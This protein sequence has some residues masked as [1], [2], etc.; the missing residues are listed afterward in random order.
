MAQITPSMISEMRKLRGTGLSLQKIASL[1]SEKHSIEISHQTISYHLGKV[2][3]EMLEGKKSVRVIHVQ[4]MDSGPRVFNLDLVTFEKERG[5]D[6]VYQH[7][8]LV[9]ELRS[10]CMHCTSL[11]REAAGESYED[12]APV[13]LVGADPKLPQVYVN[14]TNISTAQIDAAFNAHKGN[15]GVNWL[16]SKGYNRQLFQDAFVSNRLSE[17]LEGYYKSMGNEA[18]RLTGNNAKD[19]LTLHSIYGSIE[20]MQKD[21]KDFIRPDTNYWN[22]NFERAFKEFMKETGIPPGRRNR[23]LK[24]GCLDNEKLNQFYDGKFKDWANFERAILTG[25][26]L[27]KEWEEAVKLR[28]QDKKE[29]DSVKKYGWPNGPYMRQALD[30]GFKHKESALW[31]VLQQRNLLRYPDVVKWIRKDPTE[32]ERIEQFPSMKALQLH[33]AILGGVYKS[34]LVVTQKILEKYNSMS[35]PGPNFNR[36]NQIEALLQDPPFSDFCDVDIEAGSVIL[37][38][39]PRRKKRQSKKT[40]NPAVDLEPYEFL[41]KSKSKYALKV[42]KHVNERDLDDATAS[43]WRW[44]FMHGKKLLDDQRAPRF[45]ET[46]CKAITDKLGL[47]EAENNAL[48]NLRKARNDFDKANEEGNAIKPKWP[49]IQNGLSIVEKLIEAN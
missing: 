10:G 25:F 13:F 44:L 31:S 23:A 49:L 33:D 29:Y 3:K 21:L 46:M 22:Q 9:Y 47:S 17:L 36:V 20:Q 32:L 18:V 2:K 15:Q 40:V 6:T 26:S 35:F 30:S 24:E 14:M 1:L 37:N 16:S 43:T 11:P 4:S 34:E 39:K 12:W 42:V 48:H 41:S 5:E 8:N 27:R 28:C 7:G 45:A 19:T 38:L